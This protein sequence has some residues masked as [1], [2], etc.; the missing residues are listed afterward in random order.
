MRRAYNI[1]RIKLAPRGIQFPKQR[2]KICRSGVEN[3]I[4]W[5]HR[6]A[7]WPNRGFIY[8]ASPNWICE[9]VKADSCKCIPFSF[10]FIQD[11]IVRLMLKLMR[12]ERRSK[13]FV[14]KFH[15]VALV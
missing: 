1:S 11:M 8:Q 5:H 6:A 13:V 2:P 10:F 3:G 7:V 4:A 14:E 9:N 12:P 15:A